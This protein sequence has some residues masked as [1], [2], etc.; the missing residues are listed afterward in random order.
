MVS[1]MQRTIGHAAADLAEAFSALRFP[2]NVVSAPHHGADLVATLPDGTR[3]AFEIKAYKTVT[4]DL[5]RNI[6]GTP[7]DPGVTGVVVAD[8]VTPAAGD[9]LAEAGWGWLDRRGHLAVHAGSLLVDVPVPR[10]LEASGQPATPTLDT[11][12]GLDVAVALLTDP[13]RKHSIRELVAFTGRSLG[14][15]HRAVR[16]MTGEGL[17]DAGGLPLRRELFWEAADRWR[18]QRVA[19]AGAPQPGDAKR[20]EQLHLGLD[21]IGGGIGW[22]LTDAIAANIYGAPVPVRGDA[23]PDFYVPDGRIVRVA[24]ALYGEPP[25][26]E[27]RAA[28]V[29]VAPVRWAC[30]HRVDPIGLGRPHVWLEFGLVH[31][32]VAALDLASDASRGREILLDW[33]PPDPYERVW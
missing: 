21:D 16:G 31:P 27:L 32:V 7:L 19:L 23:P 10:Q 28:T 22:A 25:S 17:I 5:V 6:I 33:T 9:A 13:A 2:I 8:Q 4:P 20:T 30:E 29:A 12:V 11:G 3:L 15:I 18:P 1:N 24:R 26:P 14:A